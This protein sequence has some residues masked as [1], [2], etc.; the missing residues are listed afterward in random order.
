MKN[1]ILVI[2]TAEAKKSEAKHCD[3][4]TPAFSPRGGTIITSHLDTILMH[5]CSNAKKKMYASLLLLHI[6]CIIVAPQS[7]EGTH[8]PTL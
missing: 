6:Y 3:D 8:H 1:I 7:F 4:A 5:A 2:Y